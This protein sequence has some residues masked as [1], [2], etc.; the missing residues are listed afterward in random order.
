MQVKVCP[1]CNAENR[2]DRASCSNCY[3]SL[4]E[5]S[6]TAST[7]E[8]PVACQVQPTQAAASN[9]TQAE[10]QGQTLGERTLNSPVEQP[11]TADS[12]YGPPPAPPRPGAVSGPAFR[13]SRQPMKQGPNVGAI[14][15]IIILLAGGA[16]AGWWFFLRALPPDQVVQSFFQA[17]GDG[18][19]E[20]FK[21]YLTAASIEKI[22]TQSGGEKKAAESLKFAFSKGQAFDINKMI[23]GKPT[24]EGEEKAFVAIDL[25]EK[26]QMPPGVP[27]QLA[28]LKTELVLLR[29]SGKWKIDLQA[30]ETHMMEK[31]KELFKGMGNFMPR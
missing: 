3:A 8:E 9:E 1:K 26:P 12:P 25:K 20:K 19:Y 17:A 23:F 22:K 27:P 6:I 18:D 29:E 31:V 4:D 21:S 5:V 10:P 7:K 16:F 24:F 15:L 14:I 30:T 13:E 28:N 11:K 2:S